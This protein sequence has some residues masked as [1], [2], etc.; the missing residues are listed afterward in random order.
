MS[1]LS[2]ASLLCNLSQLY[3]K[4]VAWYASF[5]AS[6]RAVTLHCRAERQSTAAEH[7]QSV[8]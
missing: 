1:P 6:N 7:Y 3:S 5:P 8:E 2:V 4:P